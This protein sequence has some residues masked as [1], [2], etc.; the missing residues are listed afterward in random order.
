MRIIYA[1]L[2]AEGYNEKR[3]PSFE[4]TNFYLT[5]KNMSGVEVVEYPYD[6]I[7]RLGKR[8][9]NSELLSLVRREK[10]DLFF[11]FMFSDEL[12]FETLDEIK[13]IT[14]S[15]AWF[16]DDHWRL[17]NYSRHYAPHASWA[18]TTWSKARE[19]YA[20]YG[21]RNV[22]RSQWAANHNIYKP[23]ETPKTIEVSFVGQRTAKRSFVIN[24]FKEAGI[25]VYVRGFGWPGGRVSQD[26]ALNIFSASKINLNIN[27]SPSLFGLQPLARLFFRRSRSR[28]VPSFN[29]ID[30]FKSWLHIPMSQIKARPFELAACRAFVISGYADD[31]DSYYR[32]GKEMVYYRSPED[33]VEKI[34]HYLAHDGE[35]EAIAVSG[36]ER[37][38]KEHTYE[39]RFRDLFGK[40]NL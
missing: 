12:E 36:Y 26:E 39:Q 5:L 32:D 13:K 15:V 4:Y 22:I 9:F 8:K 27:N 7:L 2:Q 21:I 14:K 34:K 35:R 29:L 31:M 24:R 18:V 25:N 37:T 11:A 17:W 30:N 1:G 38:M 19:I 23:I 3:K 40:I 20:W 28:I 33:L 6:S 10:P 16:A